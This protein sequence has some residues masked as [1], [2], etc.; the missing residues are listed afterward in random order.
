MLYEQPREVPELGSQPSMGICARVAMPL[1][2]FAWNKRERNGLRAERLGKDVDLVK[3][4]TPWGLP[5]R[6]T[7]NASR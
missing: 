2:W 1:A 7:G 3:G 4:W 5:W 6:C